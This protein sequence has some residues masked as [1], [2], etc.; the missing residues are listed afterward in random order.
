MPSFYLNSYAPLVASKAGR[1][2]SKRYG[3]EPFVDGSIRREPD[4]E[5]DMPSISCLCR[6]GKFAPR[7]RAGDVVAY[8]TAKK[9]FGRRPANRRLT[10]VLRVDRIFGDHATAASWFRSQGKLLPSNCMVDNN[11]PRPIDQSHCH[12][13]GRQRSPHPEIQKLWD[14]EYLERASKHPAFVVCERIFLKLCWDAPIVSDAC[15]REAIGYLPGTQNPGALD[16]EAY[17]RLMHL[18][19]IPVPPSSP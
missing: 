9:S 12:V 1:E 11:P 15:L 5:H 4:L 8:L 6:A 19:G 13:R 3:I 14:R 17:H 10:A 7:L 16:L 18:L 2:A